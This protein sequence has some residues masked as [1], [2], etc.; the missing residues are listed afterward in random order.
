MTLYVK[1]KR[2]HKSS[3]DRG[4]AVLTLLI[5]L[6]ILCLGFFY[7]IQTNSLVGCSYQIRQQKEY[8]NDLQ[9]ENQ[10][11]ETEIAQWQSPANLEKIVESLGL[12][13]ADEVVYLKEKAVAVKK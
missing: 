12:V 5:V 3:H 11:L 10:K 4:L 9:V 6:A 7:L 1:S 2:F 8:L 13:E